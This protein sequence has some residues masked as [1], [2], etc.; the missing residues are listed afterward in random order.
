[1]LQFYVTF[2]VLQ[3]LILI[4]RINSYFQRI[5]FQRNLLLI[6]FQHYVTSFLRWKISLEFQISNF[7]GISL[8]FQMADFTRMALHKLVRRN[9][10]RKLSVSI[11]YQNFHSFKEGLILLCQGILEERRITHLH[12]SALF[13]IPLKF[14]CPIFY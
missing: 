7:I 9:Y 5:S 12:G 1:M 3:D 10:G 6:C 13:T 14:T 11:K 8:E 2:F 4:D